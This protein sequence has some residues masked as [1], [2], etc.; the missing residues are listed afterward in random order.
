MH[1]VIQVDTLCH[2]IPGFIDKC[3]AAG[4][5]QVFIGLENINPDNLAAMNKKQ[6]RITEYREM[7]LAG[8]QHPVV[9]WGAYIVGFPNDT[10][11]SILHD[12][13]LIKRELPVDLLNISI[14]TPLPGSEDHKRLH[15]AGVWMDPDLNNYDLAHRVSHHP[16]MTD[17]E[18]DRVYQEAWDTYYTYEHMVTVV[19]RMFALGSNRRLMTVNGLIGFGV[20]TRQHGM[21]SYDMGLIRRKSRKSRRPGLPLENPLVFYAKYFLHTVKST[22]VIAFSHWRLLRKMLQIEKDAQRHSYIDTAITPPTREDLEILG[23]FNDTRGGQE[24]V[25]KL[26][27]RRERPGSARSA[28]PTR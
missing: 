19:R 13:E 26:K 23:L 14:L 20:V 21:R 24:A 10:R 1:Y 7:L 22:S 16:K 2:R 3:V 25:L 5:G 18:L 12:V 11:D 6:N 9:I 27:R 4:V 8:K 15:D 17:A 28:W